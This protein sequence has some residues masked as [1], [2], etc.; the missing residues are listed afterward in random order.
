MSVHTQHQMVPKFRQRS[1]SL[2]SPDKTAGASL[3]AAALALFCESEA[4]RRNFFSGGGTDSP[5]PAV[6]EILHSKRIGVM[7]LTSG[8][9]KS[10]V[11]WPFDTPKAIS[12]CWSFGTKPLSLTVSEIFNGE[13]NAMV[14]MTLIRSLHRVSKN[15][16][17]YFCYNY[18]KLSP[19]LTIF[20]TKMTNCLKLY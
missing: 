1:S 20:D 7:S 6:L 19:N 18:V 10:S 11:T 8:H 13:C 14:D 17:N 15:K 4:S 16:Q 2:S 9:V 5:S 3:L 12:Y